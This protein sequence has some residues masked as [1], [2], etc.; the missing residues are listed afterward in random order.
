MNMVKLPAL[1]IAAVLA[2]IAVSVHWYF[3][4]GE[5]PRF[6]LPWLGALI[7]FAGLFVM[8]W[9]KN[10]FKREGLAIMPTSKTA[11][12]TTAGPYRFT[13]NPMYL[14]TVLL[15]LGLSLYIG[16]IPFYLAAIGCFAVLNSVFC[17]FEE[18]KLI[19]AFG[20]EYREY[21]NRVRRWL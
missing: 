21:R 11:H 17:C 15:L 9:A 7:G 8:T 20:Q 14:G 13:R 18:N 3:N 10:V 19:E 12:L 6:S 4:L 5:R 2:L 16:T 1:L